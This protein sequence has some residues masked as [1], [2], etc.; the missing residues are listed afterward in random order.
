MLQN[1]WVTSELRQMNADIMKMKI[2]EHFINSINKD[3]MMSE[4]IQEL[5]TIKKTSKS[6]SEQVLI[7]TTRAELKRAQKVFM[8]AKKTIKSLMLLKSM[9][10]RTIHLTEQNEI[11]E[12]LS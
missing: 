8:E 2:K 9:S 11:G 7:L 10:K 5:T 6:T 12:K 1:E 4:F 3:H